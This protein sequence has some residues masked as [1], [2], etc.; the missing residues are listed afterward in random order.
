MSRIEQGQQIGA[1]AMIAIAL[2]VVSYL[3]VITGNEQAQGAMIGVLTAG[4]GY[5]LRG[6][7]EAPKS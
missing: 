2:L 4:V 7:V 1:Y 5:A 6:R 3:A